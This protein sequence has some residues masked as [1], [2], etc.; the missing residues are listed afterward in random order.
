MY[1]RV[2][3]GY[4]YF[5][6]LYLIKINAIATSPLKTKSTFGHIPYLL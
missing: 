6:Y 2:E 4:M 5:N 3:T 1:S